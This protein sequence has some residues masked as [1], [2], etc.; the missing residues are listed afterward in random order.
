MF[1]DVNMSFV[2]P[3]VWPSIV[4]P[5]ALTG[6][7]ELS[8]SRASIVTVARKSCAF[9]AGAAMHNTSANAPRATVGVMWKV[10]CA[11]LAAP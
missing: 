5:S 7:K 3:D 2:E 4:E 11:P 8:E 6:S 10:V 1:A 9:A